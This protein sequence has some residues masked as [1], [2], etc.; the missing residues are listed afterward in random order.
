M[1]NLL[2]SIQEKHVKLFAKSFTKK[3]QEFWM[4]HLKVYNNYLQLILDSFEEKE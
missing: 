4:Q 1:I 3:G 2:F